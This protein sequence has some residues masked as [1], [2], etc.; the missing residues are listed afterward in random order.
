MAVVFLSSTFVDL[1]AHRQKVIE[2]IDRLVHIG[3]DVEWRAMEAFPASFRT[4]SLAI[5]LD[6]L[7]DSDIY[8]GALGP[9]YGTIPP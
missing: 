2:A 8:I 1:R 7:R 3:Y 5:A 4:K 9:R 6:M